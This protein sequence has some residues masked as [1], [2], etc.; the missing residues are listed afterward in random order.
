MPN[1]GRME[2]HLSMH[3]NRRVNSNGPFVRRYLMQL[4]CIYC[5]ESHSIEKPLKCVTTECGKTKIE[6][7]EILFI[8]C[9][10]CNKKVVSI[11]RCGESLS[12]NCKE[13]LKRRQNSNRFSL[14][15][16][17]LRPLSLAILF[18]FSYCI[19]ISFSSSIFDWSRSEREYM[20]SLRWRRIPYLPRRKGIQTSPSHT[21][22]TSECV[23]KSTW[24]RK[25][26]AKMRQRTI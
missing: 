15:E 23:A 6:I 18:R 4:E 3:S 24:P 16:Y 1:G 11:S 25:C 17:V 9:W 13:W 26:I 2:T 10:K 5:Y 14:D 12:D 20:V 19:F 21:A 22:P 7:C 8:K